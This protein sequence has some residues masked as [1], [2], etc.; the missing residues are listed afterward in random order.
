MYTTAYATF[1]GDAFPSGEVDIV[2][3]AG[4]GGDD[5]ENQI[6]IRSKTDITGGT[7]VPTE[8]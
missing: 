7:V 4:Q 1:A 5:S 6:N 3:I 2:G 8:I